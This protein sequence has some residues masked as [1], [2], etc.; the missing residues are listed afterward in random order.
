MYP[1]VFES[2]G[3]YL[4]PTP[5]GPARPR[6][7]GLELGRLLRRQHDDGRGRGLGPVELGHVALEGVAALAAHCAQRALEAR[8]RDAARELGVLPQRV[9]VLVPLVALVAFEA[10]AGGR[11][12]ALVPG[13][14][15]VDLLGLGVPPLRLAYGACGSKGL[16]ART[17]TTA[18]RELT[19]AKG[20]LGS[21]SRRRHRCYC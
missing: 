2:R 7:D 19:R 8:E 21:A 15:L 14:L 11:L 12:H 18:G 4:R 17:T 13:Q 3:Y 1:P 5:A 20:N 16:S 10:V 9:V 6:L